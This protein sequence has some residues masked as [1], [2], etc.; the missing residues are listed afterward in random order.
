M[1]W[2]HRRPLRRAA[3][4][5]GLFPI[6]VPTPDDLAALG[7]E[8]RGLRTGDGPFD[9]VMELPPGADAAPWEQAGATWVLT[10]F[11]S[12]PRERDVR[13]AIDAGPH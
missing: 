10:G 5:D 12:Q 1:R 4:Y 8:L 2:P 7:D 3:Q 6:E 13:A 9:L 11:G